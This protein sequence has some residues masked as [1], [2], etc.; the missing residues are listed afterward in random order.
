M[1]EF[2]FKCIQGQIMQGPNIMSEVDSRNPR[3]SN[4]AHM[5]PRFEQRRLNEHKILINKEF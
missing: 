2:K 1:N 3:F 4:Y 5:L